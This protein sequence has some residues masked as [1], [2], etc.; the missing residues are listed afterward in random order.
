MVNKWF[1]FYLMKVRWQIQRGWVVWGLTVFCYLNNKYL[2]SDRI[3]CYLSRMLKP[4][5]HLPLLVLTG[6][7][8]TVQET[9]GLSLVLLRACPTQEYS[10]K[11]C[12][13]THRIRNINDLLTLACGLGFGPLS[14]RLASPSEVSNKFV[15]RVTFKNYNALIGKCV[16]V[17]DAIGRRARITAANDC[18]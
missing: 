6:L 14:I 8:L 2:L 4:C 13:I 16:S 12:R 7:S 9:V 18:K 17:P 3:P 15:L 1:S 5:F 11:K 10:K